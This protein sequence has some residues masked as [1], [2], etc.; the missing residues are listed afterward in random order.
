MKRSASQIGILKDAFIVL[1][2]VTA[3]VLEIKVG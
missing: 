3:G 2:D 1:Q